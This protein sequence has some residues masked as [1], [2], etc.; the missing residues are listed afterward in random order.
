MGVRCSAY[1]LL[2]TM[3]QKLFGQMQIAHKIRAVDEQEVAKIVIEKHFMRDIKGNLRK[4]SQQQFRCVSCNEKYRRPPLAGK[5][6]KCK[7]RLLFTV[8][9][10]SIV[11][12]LQPALDMAKKYNLP[13]YLK[14]NLEITQESIESIFGRDKE[15]Q[16]ALKAW[17]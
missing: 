12:Y 11:K 2:P 10:G 9:E 5:C 13:N 1:K 6:L 14:Q 7:G 16:E 4:F 3:E 15:R 17:F 8:S